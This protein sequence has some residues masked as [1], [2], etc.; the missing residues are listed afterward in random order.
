MKRI[1]VIGSINLDFVAAVEHVPVAGE[2]ILAENMETFPGGK[3]A[4]QAYAAG[5]LGGNVSML[6]AVG[7]DS[8]GDLALKNLEDVGVDVSRCKR[9]QGV[10]TGNAWIAVN[11]EG[12]NSIIVLQGANRYVT[13][14]YIDQNLD[15]LRS[16]DIV[17]MQ[18]EIPIDTVLHT[19]Q[20]AR[21]YGKMVILDPAPAKENIP[22]EMYPLIDIIKPNEGEL[23][24][25][26]GCSGEDYE[27]GAEMLLDKGC[28]SVLVSLGENG[29][30]YVA[31]GET[32]VRIPGRKV[33]AVDTT[34][35][36]D[37]FIAGLAVMLAKGT[38]ME[39]AIEFGQMVSAI[40]VTRK[41]AQNSIPGAGEVQRYEAVG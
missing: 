28:K 18:L 11:A 24:V 41:G 27:I 13:K 35:A 17:I 38:S 2:T 36:G 4:N 20:L 14:E 6:A 22:D 9:V 1:L 15:L 26:T 21:K 29:V 40:T 31:D 37:S 8:W 30:Y 33:N 39:D 25:L 19:A 16:C 12:D 23:S 10:S 3:G 5:K 32:G 7:R 34:A